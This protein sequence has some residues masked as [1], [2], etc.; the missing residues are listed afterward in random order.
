MDVQ[1]FGI[2]Y[3]CDTLCSYHTNNADVLWL[4]TPQTDLLLIQ[5]SHID[6]FYLFSAICT[7]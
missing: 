5:F 1:S 2:F 6:I 4:T 3:I 7:Y